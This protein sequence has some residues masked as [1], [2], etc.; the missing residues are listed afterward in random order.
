M[1]YNFLIKMMVFMFFSC[2]R[3]FILP[4]L[5]FSTPLVLWLPW[6]DMDFKATQKNTSN[7]E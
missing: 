5:F 3:I 7:I 1:A 6:D 4:S 2:V